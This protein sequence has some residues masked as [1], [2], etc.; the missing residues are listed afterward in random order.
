MLFHHGLKLEDDLIALDNA[1]VDDMVRRM[2]MPE[3]ATGEDLMDIHV[4]VSNSC[5]SLQ[6]VPPNAAILVDKS[7]SVG[8]EV[9][10]HEKPFAW[11]NSDLQGNFFDFLFQPRLQPSEGTQNFNGNVS[12]LNGELGV[13]NDLHGARRLGSTYFH[14]AN[15]QFSSHLLDISRSTPHWNGHAHDGSSSSI[16]GPGA[17]DAYSFQ[18]LPRRSSSLANLGHQLPVYSEDD[19]GSS[20]PICHPRRLAGKVFRYISEKYPLRGGEIR[21]DL[22]PSAYNDPRKVHMSLIQT[23]EDEFKVYGKYQKMM[24]IGTAP[25]ASL[26]QRRRRKP[27][28]DVPVWEP[29][30]M[31]SVF[32]EVDTD[33][34]EKTDY[35]LKIPHTSCFGK[36]NMRAKGAWSRSA[37]KP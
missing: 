12:T 30:S 15:S 22:L 32:T 20:R 33:G 10:T 8:P 25:P 16:V 27:D 11:E 29:L 26:S 13:L 19:A 3:Y 17:L 28:H 23:A 37:K 34:L 9:Q 6:S 35:A 1:S 36:I 18:K 5:T 24:K 4:P 2:L 14:P 21:L 31:F 7:W